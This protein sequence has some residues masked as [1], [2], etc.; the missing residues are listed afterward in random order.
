[1]PMDTWDVNR[2]KRFD[3]LD[4]T[5]ATDNA[6]NAASGTPRCLRTSIHANAWASG[7]GKEKSESGCEKDLG[8]RAGQ[9]HVVEF[10]SAVPEVDSVGDCE[11]RRDPNQ[12]PVM[13]PARPATPARTPIATS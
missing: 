4:I 8:R 7:D 1:M 13:E 3:C 6:R 5:E 11:D 2:R 10:G 12:N 9:I